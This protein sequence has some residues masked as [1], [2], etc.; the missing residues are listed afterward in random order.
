MSDT[1]QA[2]RPLWQPPPDRIRDSA[3]TAFQAWVETTTGLQFEDYAALHR[4]S[5]DEPAAF[6]Q[7][8]WEFCDVRASTPAEATVRDLDQFPGSRWFPG[9]RLNFAEN[10]LRY[11]D[12]NVALVGLLENGQRQVITYAELQSQVARLAAALRAHG[13][14]QGDRVAALMPNV[15]ETV[16]AMLATASIGAVWSSCSPDFGIDGAC[17]RFGQITPRLLFTT[18]AY[19]YNGRSIDCL[20]K[21]AAIQGKIASIETVIVFPVIDPAAT[22]KPDQV[23]AADFIADAAEVPLAFEQLP[24]DHP[25]YIMYSSGTT[26]IPK[27]IVHGAGGTLLQHL[28]EHKLHVDLRRDDTLFYFTT[29]GWMMWNWLVSG[30]AS[31]ATLLLY[32]GSPFAQAGNVLLDAIDAEAIT[33]FGT[34]AK[35]ISALEKQGHEPAKTH[36]LASL[37]TILSTGSPLTHSSFNY[38][39]RSIKAD[40]HLASIS[41]G[42]DIIS[43]FVLGN[44]N[45][46]VYAGE[47]QCAGLGMAV[48]FRTDDG[49]ADISEAGELVCARPFPSVP[50]GFWQ[51]DADQRFLAA[52]FNQRPGYWTHGDYG[53]STQQGGIIIHGRSDATLNPSGVRIGTAEIYR[54]VETFAEIIDSIVVGQRWEDDERIVL[55]VVLAES[56]SLDTAL[57]DDIKTTI[58]A[59][60][61]PRHVPARIIAVPDI[62]RTISGKIVEL[63][64]KKVIHGEPVTNTDALANPEALDY[65]RD[66]EE[67][68]H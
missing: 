6:W 43:C 49:I 53:E 22:L 19:L 18:D 25:L 7:A 39:Y 27:C 50:L 15:P 40:V 68:R 54:Q 38:V 65:F 17:D 20:D 8:T 46:P 55:F 42:T 67:L 29:C 63:A 9:S 51:D 30:L 36:S 21:A 37:K 14:T 4:W 26:G 33:I 31:G 16:L 48:E 10:L 52:Y 41:G 11:R 45:L 1:A 44:P 64:V 47:I 13:I 28:K 58:R 3:M 66:L 35:F 24:F 61:T 5:V 59:Q 60:A 2:M 32:D 57:I 23:R 62:P 34:S 56:G 12:D